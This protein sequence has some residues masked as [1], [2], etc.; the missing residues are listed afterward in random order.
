MSLLTWL[1]CNKRWSVCIK[2]SWWVHSDK[3][4]RRPGQR[5]GDDLEIIYD[6]LLHIKALAHLSNTVSQSVRFSFKATVHVS[7]KAVN[8]L[9][10]VDAMFLFLRLEGEVGVT[11]SIYL[12]SLIG[13]S[14]ILISWPLLA[15]I[16]GAW[17]PPPIFQESALCVL[18]H[19][20]NNEKSHETHSRRWKWFTNEVIKPSIFNLLI[21]ISLHYPFEITAYNKRFRKGKISKKIFP[22]AVRM[23]CEDS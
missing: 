14:F 7:K 5:T 21:P 11:V 19:Y 2:S 4:V 22:C 3:C 6:E 18:L 13:H 12:T 10:P 16:H 23:D 15:S 1:Q 8:T 9:E 17:S 20:Y